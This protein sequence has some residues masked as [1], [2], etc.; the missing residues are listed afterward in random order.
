M[1]KKGEMRGRDV[2]ELANGKWMA[3]DADPRA[4]AGLPAWR[5]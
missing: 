5:T 2:R 1:L 3:G 4:R